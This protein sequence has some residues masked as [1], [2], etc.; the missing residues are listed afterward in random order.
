M[1][2]KEVEYQIKEL[3]DNLKHGQEDADSN[4]LQRLANKSMR[5]ELGKLKRSI[6]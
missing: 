6:R 3:E 4:F 1:N 2:K 5:I